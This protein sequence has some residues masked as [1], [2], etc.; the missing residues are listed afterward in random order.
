MFIVH[1]NADVV[2][3]AY[4][5]DFKAVTSVALSVLESFR[6]PR[7]FPLIGDIYPDLG[8]PALTETLF[9]RGLGDGRPGYY[10]RGGQR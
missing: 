10:Q 8:P 7:R 3:L 1:T 9:G 4:T 5:T 6:L 2:E